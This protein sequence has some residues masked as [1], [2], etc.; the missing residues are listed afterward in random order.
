LVLS[1]REERVDYAVSPVFSPPRPRKAARINISSRFF[2]WSCSSRDDD[3]VMIMV[4][5]VIII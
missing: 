5:I 1:P 4:A 2:A 3:S